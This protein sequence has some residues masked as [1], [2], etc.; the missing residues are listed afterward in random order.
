[1]KIHVTRTDAQQEEVHKQESRQA[2]LHA[3]VEELRMEHKR[4]WNESD[5]AKAKIANA[6]NQNRKLQQQLNTAETE[7]QKLVADRDSLT[8]TLGAVQLSLLLLR[9]KLD[10]PRTC[11][12]VVLY[13]QSPCE[14]TLRLPRT[15]SR[16]PKHPASSSPTRTISW[17]L[18]NCSWRVKS[19]C[20]H[21]SLLRFKSVRSALCLLLRAVAQLIVRN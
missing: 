9:V 10:T 5:E 13:L 7:M 19:S 6:E 4:I 18:T 15:T 11:A 17:R 12:V 8:T 20:K 1:M 3:A 16:Q 21:S 2:V 14:L